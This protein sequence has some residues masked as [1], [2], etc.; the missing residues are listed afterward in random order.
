MEYMF[1]PLKRYAE[2]SGRSRR[3]EFWMF[4]L[5]QFIIWCV[6]LGLAVAMLGSALMAGSRGSVGGI[7][8]VGGSAMILV[9]IVVIVALALFIPGLAVAVRR[10]HDTDRSGWWVGGYVILVIVSN[11]LQSVTGSGALSL[12]LSLVTLV[13]AI[14]LLVFYCLDGTKGPNKYGP[15]PKGQV[16]AQVFA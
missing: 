15:D 7:M 1:L 11:V 12:I 2:F 5:F 4:A 13:Y 16:D 10:L 8:A 6:I 14:T 3:M 9:V